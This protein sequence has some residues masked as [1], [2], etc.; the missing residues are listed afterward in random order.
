M[1]LLDTIGGAQEFATLPAVASRVLALLENDNAD[2]REITQVIETDVSLTLKI[3]QMANSPLYAVRSSV[4][5]LNQAVLALGL[6]RISNIVLSVSIF[7]KFMVLSHG[8]S[9]QFMDKFWHHSSSTGM[10]AK[11]L[12]SKI[13]R[14]FRDV[15]FIA[16]LLHDIG[17]MAMIQFDPNRYEQSLQ[18]ITDKNL[19]DL[20]AEIEIFGVDHQTTGE[21]IA[22]LWKLPKEIQT[23]VGHH[24]HPEEL[25]DLRELTSVVR[26]ADL[27]C[28]LWGAGI[29]EK[30]DE[31]NIVELPAWQVLCE[32]I[33]ALKTLDI[34][35][36]TFELEEEFNR[37]T[38][39]LKLV[40]QDAN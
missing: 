10:V 36:F 8:K 12:A 14:S 1:S 22:R 25:S 32:S 29:G 37:A 40:T 4:T 3:L 7:S 15:E 28:E 35:I 16:G 33:P 24:H 9:T 5:S 23:I 27:L 26:I 11:S 21:L 13:K 39:F 18:L 2:L 38:S 17:K 20:E 31:I 30:I 19:S 6:N 34:E